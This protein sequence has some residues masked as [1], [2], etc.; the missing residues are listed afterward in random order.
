M[1]HAI[2][3]EGR[4]RDIEIRAMDESFIV[5]RKMFHAP[6]TADSLETADPEY[7]ASGHADGR[8]KVFEAFFRKQI[9]VVGSCMILAWDG[10]GVIGKMHFTTREMHEAIGGPE[11]WS[12]PACYCVDH[13]GFAPAIRSFSDE[14]LKRLLMSPS[15]TL[16][17]LCFNIGHTDAQWHGL[18]IAKAMVEY[19]KQWADAKG[20]R[21]LEARSCPDITPPTV[22]GNWMLRR[23]A[24][25]R[26]GF[27]VTEY[28]HV[29]PE[30]ASHRLREI[31][32]VLSG[33]RAALEWGNYY[34]ENVRC[35]AAD[36]AWRSEYDMNYLMAC[37]LAH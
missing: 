35:L 11:C 19:L 3:F 7:L 16:R 9:Q 28:T 18:G 32:A 4:P 27:R 22:V 33:E 14:E 10:D 29:S 25:E 37:D 13:D 34:A 23:S 2:Q 12:S 30:E 26:R 17:I 8:F 21:R 20:W 1:K 24:F 6:L 36:P 31:E 5:W 15:R